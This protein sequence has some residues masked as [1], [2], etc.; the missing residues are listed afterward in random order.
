LPPAPIRER[1]VIKM[2]SKHYYEL[3][4]FLIFLSI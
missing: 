2:G 1:V 3:S 4:F